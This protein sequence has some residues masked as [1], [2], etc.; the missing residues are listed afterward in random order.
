G[1]LRHRDIDLGCDPAA[2][3]GANILAMSQRSMKRSVRALEKASARFVRPTTRTTRPESY[4]ASAARTTS[5]G[6][7]NGRNLPARPGTPESAYRAVR[8]KPGHTVTTRTPLPRSSYDSPSPNASTKALV[9][10]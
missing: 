9:A 10:A 5:S 7:A 2:A 8:V 1:A 3:I 4:A 6:V